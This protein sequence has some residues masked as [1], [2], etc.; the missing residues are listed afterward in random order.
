MDLGKLAEL[1]VHR[2]C[3]ECRAEFDTIPATKASEEIPALRQL[4]EHLSIHQPTGEQ[5][6]KA[7]SLLDGSDQPTPKR[8]DV[9]SADD[10]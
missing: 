3:H 9:D 7:Y 2:V 5:W 6:A 8:A 10:D 1:S 4:A